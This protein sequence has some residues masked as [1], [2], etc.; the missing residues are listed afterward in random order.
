MAEAGVSA[1]Q[2]AELRANL[3]ARSAPEGPATRRCRSPN[4]QKKRR[5]T[6]IRRRVFPALALQRDRYAKS[7]ES[8]DIAV[9]SVVTAS[10]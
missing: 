1:R 5:R 10:D 9:D 3:D 2:D 4:L 7:K 6:C 8:T